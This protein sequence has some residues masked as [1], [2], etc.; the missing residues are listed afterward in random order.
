MANI[1]SRRIELADL[2]NIASPLNALD[3]IYQRQSNQIERQ[4]GYLSEQA[5]QAQEADPGVTALNTFKNIL[6]FGGAAAKLYQTHKGAQAQGAADQEAADSLKLAAQFSEYGLDYTTPENRAKVVE[7]IERLKKNELELTKFLN[8]EYP[9][10]KYF[11]LRTELTKNSGANLYRIKQDLGYRNAQNLGPNAGQVLNE[12]GALQS[13]I[14]FAKGD[15]VESQRIIEAAGILSFQ[16]LGFS[17]EYILENYSKQITELAQTKGA[18]SLLNYKN[19]VL[20]EQTEKLNTQIDVARESND[21]NALGNAV[22]E[23][24]ELLAIDF[25]GGSD[26][27]EVKSAARTKAMEIT[28]RRLYRSGRHG[29]LQQHELDD[30]E[31]AKLKNPIGGKKDSTGELLFSKEHIQLIQKGINEKNAATHALHVEKRENDIK[32]VFGA[33]VNGEVGEQGIQRALTNYLSAGGKKTDDLYKELENLN[34]SEQSTEAYEREKA[35]FEANL[36]TGRYG[37]YKDQIKQIRNHRLKREMELKAAGIAKSRKDNGWDENDSDNRVKGMIINKSTLNLTKLGGSLEGHPAELGLNYISQLYDTTYADLYFA[38]PNPESDLTI[39]AQAKDIVEAKLKE[40]GFYEPAGSDKNPGILTMSVD[41]QFPGLKA[42]L[43]SQTENK[44][45]DNINVTMYQVKSMWKQAEAQGLGTKKGIVGLKGVLDIDE[46]T[47]V[48]ENMTFDDDGK[49]IEFSGYPRDVLLKADLFG[50]QPSELVKGQ[51]Q[52]FKQ[53]ASNNDQL[54]LKAL[55]LEK[56]L[57][58]LP[59]SDVRVRSFLEGIDNPNDNTLA[60]YE[61]LGIRS[62]P[63]AAWKRLLKLEE[64]IGNLGQDQGPTYAEIIEQKKERIR[65]QQ[66]NKAASQRIP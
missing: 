38:S 10:D 27:P 35:A 8:S 50:V 28:A 22:Q 56:N 4:L 36:G 52:A 57:E 31:K 7:A 16:K 34:P 44:L 11:K 39:G 13:R 21:P 18:L 65:I 46:L 17:K 42:Y 61:T 9:G 29:S 55:N 64:S 15:P 30:L 43:D 23:Q 60:Y 48:S 33:A 54:L 45:G 59:D 25:A 63:P 58:N 14:D 24:I 40:L 26:D 1:Y 5:K 20:Q 51:I 32:T 12:N 3:K 66:Q 41:N 49:L 2:N 6:Q 19:I 37:N 53:G 47:A 62:I